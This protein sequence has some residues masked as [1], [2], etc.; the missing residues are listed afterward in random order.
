MH[1]RTT[2][3]VLTLTLTLGSGAAGAAATAEAETFSHQP[4]TEVLERFVDERGL[5]DYQGLADDRA[6]F[7]RY[8]R[9]VERHSP[10]S[11]PGMFP[12]RDHELAYYINAYNAQVFAGVIARGPE[13]DSVWGFLGT[14]Y[15]FFVGMDIVVGGRETNLKKLED[16]TIREGFQDPRIHAALNCASLG[17]PRLPRQAFT[18]ERLDQQLDAAMSEFVTSPVGVQV[19]S[20]ERTARLS[21]IFDWFRDDF[22]SSERRQGNADPKLLD[23]VN[24]YRGDAGEIPRGYAVEFMSYDKKI[25]RQSR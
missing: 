21:K 7:D 16:V 13:D 24:R 9:S 18:G 4:W 5:V 6:T 25:N 1:T 14:G 15:G 11:D 10:E 19:D 2:L 8:L 12:S 3:A 20:G 17:C 22:L 23:Y